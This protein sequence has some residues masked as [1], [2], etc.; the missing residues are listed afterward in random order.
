M[1]DFVLGPDR[2]YC[3]VCLGEGVIRYGEIISW[4]KANKPDIVIVREELD[5]KTA[6]RDIS[7][8]RELWEKC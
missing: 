1:K 7:Y 6:R 3:P 8:M 2:E 4:L 5:P